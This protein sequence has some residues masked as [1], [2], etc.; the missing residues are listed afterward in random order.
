MTTATKIVLSLT[1][2]AI[3]GTIGYITYKKWDMPQL[4][5]KSDKKMTIKHRG[6]KSI[7]DVESLSKNGVSQTLSGNKW[8]L[9]PSYGN[10][11]DKSTLNGLHIK[12]IKNTIHKTFYF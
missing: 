6:K 3:V 7:I 1:G 11:S 12:D 5:S 9:S 4:V 8:N 10:E 2:L